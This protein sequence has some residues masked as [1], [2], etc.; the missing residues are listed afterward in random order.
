MVTCIA[1]DKGLLHL[2]GITSS[3]ILAAI[4]DRHAKDVVVAECKN[5]ETWGAR[6]LLKL[7][8]WVLRRSYSPLTT[9]GYEIKVSRQDFEN[10]QKWTGYIDLCHEFF[11]VCPAGL[12]RATDL[13]AS[14]GI[15][16]VSAS[17][18]LHIKKK[19]ER[20]KPD[21]EKL[22]RLLIYV[23]MAR[24]RIVD[25]MWDVNKEEPLDPLQEKRKLVE[26]ATASNELAIFVKGHICQVYDQIVA[27]EHDLK[28]RENYVKQFEEHLARLGITWD[29]S[30]SEWQDTMR[31][32]NQIAALKK[33]LDWDTLGRMKNL[34]Q[35][36]VN[37]ANDLERIQK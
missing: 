1:K 20:T 34:G 5:G 11:F 14:I 29:S 19:A 3:Q 18:K 33:A 31:V 21:I 8:A 10:D 12:I 15:I 30:K 22:N 9:I 35:M 4:C 17:G 24:S 36:L 28:W 6:D 25:N 16:W 37:T 2:N 23:V 27:K 26:L 7:D 13:P 32:D